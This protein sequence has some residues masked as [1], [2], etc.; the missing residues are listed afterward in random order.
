MQPD[1]QFETINL[2]EYVE[3]LW[4]QKWLIIIPTILISI[5]VGI[6][7]FLQ[8]PAWEVDAIILPSKYFSQSAPG[9]FIEVFVVSSQ[10]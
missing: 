9:Q 5:A 2:M 1:E 10:N 8:T 7:S 6:W 3:I 4:K